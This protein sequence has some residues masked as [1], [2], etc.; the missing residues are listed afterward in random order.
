MTTKTAALT[1]TML[2]IR[3]KAFA[4][5]RRTRSASAS[6]LLRCINPATYRTCVC[7]TNRELMVIWSCAMS[8]KNTGGDSE[9]T[10]GE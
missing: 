8:C 3:K 2:R 7:V 6:Y 5:V 10:M 9:S 1:S 4:G